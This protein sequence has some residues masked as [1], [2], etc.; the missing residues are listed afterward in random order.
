M[1][2]AALYFVVSI[3]MCALESVAGGLPEQ[4]DAAEDAAVQP[5]SAPAA[6]QDS[7]GIVLLQRQ[8]GL[9]SCGPGAAQRKAR[10]GVQRRPPFVVLAV[11]AVVAAGAGA[12]VQHDEAAYSLPYTIL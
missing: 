9:R 8:R 4:G 11:R 1:S 7:A 6:A 10:I 12:G 2:S 3:S 5:S